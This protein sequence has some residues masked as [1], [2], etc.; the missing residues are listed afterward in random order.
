MPHSKR[1]RYRKEV[2]A[3]DINYNHVMTSANTNLMKLSPCSKWL[4]SSIPKSMGRG[5]DSKNS[6]LGYCWRLHELL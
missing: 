6:S 3:R 2:Q 4:Q 5:K 1:K